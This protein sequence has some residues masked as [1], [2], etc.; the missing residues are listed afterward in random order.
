ML[1]DAGIPTTVMVAPVIPA[2]NDSEI[3]RILDA[4][5]HAGV[6][7]ASYVLLRLPLEVRDLFREWLRANFPDREKHVFTLIRQMR[8]GKDYDA[9]WGERM[10]GSGPY[11]DMIRQRFE[12]A[13]ARLGLNNE[14]TPLTTEHFRAPRGGGGEQLS[15][16]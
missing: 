3:E 5:A 6:K 12:T 10:T 2:L 8:G 11:A 15:L 4:A 14:R 1:A 13:C 7:E 16:F 9:K